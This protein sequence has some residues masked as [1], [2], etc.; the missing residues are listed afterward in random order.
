M[1]WK[2]CKH[3]EDHCSADCHHSLNV[4][5]QTL[6]PSPPEVPWWYSHCCIVDWCDYKRQDGEH[7][8]RVLTEETEVFWSV[9]DFVKNFLWLCG[10]HLL[11]D[12]KRLNRPV[13]RSSSVLDIDLQYTLTITKQ[14]M[15]FVCSTDLVTWLQWNAGIIIIINYT[16]DFPVMTCHVHA[17]KSR[18]A[19][20]DRLVLPSCPVSISRDIQSTLM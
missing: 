19:S 1:S 7:P 11:G 9:Q 13:K 20:R 14:L 8:K 3:C 4:T 17:V 15:L 10:G 12:R 18:G 5:L 16:C 6:T 2:L